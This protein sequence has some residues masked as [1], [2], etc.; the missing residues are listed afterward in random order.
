[1]AVRGR[2]TVLVLRALGLGDLLTSLPSLRALRAGFPD[3]RVVLATAAWLAPLALHSRAVDCV[4]PVRPLGP[5]PARRPAVAV[6]LHGRGPESHRVLLATEPRRLIAFRHPQVPE[7]AGLPRWLP[8]G[9][10]VRRW[11]RLLRECGV[12]ADPERLE[13]DPAGLPR[14]DALQGV[15]LLHPGAGA[16]ARRWPVDRWSAVAWH[17]A[18][19]G[20][21]VLVTAGPGEESLALCVAVRAGLGPGAVWAGAD[22]LRLAG[23]VAGAGRVVS[24]DT[25]VAHLATA[26]GRPSVALFGP[27]SPAE[28]GPPAG[29]RHLVLWSGR[30]GDPHGDRP[31]PGLLEIGTEEVVQALAALPS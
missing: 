27:V 21:R 18:A 13:L 1:M 5:V 20:R 25:G 14:V 23:L 31:D 10:E 11:C 30:L 17:E 28:W 4:L 9:H 24:G 15:T 26:L 22:V 7:S 8:G 2:P 19:H 3:H 12:P 6:N 29:T 16:A